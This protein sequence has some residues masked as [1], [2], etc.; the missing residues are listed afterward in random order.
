MKKKRSGGGLRRDDKEEGEGEQG[1]G[2]LGR[3]SGFVC[4]QLTFRHASND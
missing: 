3:C 4:L 2:E 1:M